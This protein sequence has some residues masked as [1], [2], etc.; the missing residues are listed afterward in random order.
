MVRTVATFLSLNTA[1]LFLNAFAGLML[2]RHMTKGDYAQYTIYTFAIGA[3]TTLCTGGVNMA[4]SSLLGRFWGNKSRLAAALKVGQKVRLALSAI[5]LPAVC[6]YTSWLLRKNDASWLTVTC[7]DL[8]VTIFW[9][10]DMKSRL[11]T[12]VLTFANR[13]NTLQRADLVVGFLRLILFWGGI[14]AAILVT[15][16][17][18]LINSCVSL[19]KQSFVVRLFEDL[20]PSSK[21]RSDTGGDDRAEI[22]SFVKR[23]LPFDIF[24]CLQPQLLLYLLATY[25]TTSDTAALGALSRINQLFLPLQAALLAFGIPYFSRKRDRPLSSFVKLS[26]LCLA[27]GLVLVSISFVVPSLLLWLVGSNYAHLT[28]EVRVAC[29]GTALTVWLGSSWQLLANRGRNVFVNVSIVC[30]LIWLGVGVYTLDFSRLTDILWLQAGAQACLLPT[31]LL[32][33]LYLH[34]QPVRASSGK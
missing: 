25:A 14:Q 1:A 9:I 15:A 20:W 8:A 34:L 10:S 27:P 6:V 5:F 7:V 33:A 11:H 17:A 30:T 16:V 26:A 32:E 13:N 2:A 31:V 24:Y 19:L 18:A 21:R 22:F 3:L 4:F 29:I 23:Q 28:A 12:L